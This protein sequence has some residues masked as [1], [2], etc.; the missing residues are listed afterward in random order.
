MNEQFYKEMNLDSTVLYS[1]DKIK[2]LI[3]KNLIVYIN[4]K[5][6]KT[7]KNS[8][9]SFEEWS[10]TWFSYN[11]SNV[12]NMSLLDKNVREILKGYFWLNPLINAKKSNRIKIKLRRSSLNRILFSKP[13]IRQ[14][15]NKTIITLYIYNKDKKFSYFKLNKLRIKKLNKRNEIQ[16]SIISKKI[17]KKNIAISSVNNKRKITQKNIPENLLI[18][19]KENA[20]KKIKQNTLSKRKI[21]L[22]KRKS[23]YFLHNIIK[24]KYFFMKSLEL[25]NKYFNIKDYINNHHS[26]Y[27]NKLYKREILYLY[28]IKIISINNIRF[29]NWFLLGLKNIISN[30]Y[31]KNIELNLVNL[32]YL[33]YNSNILS[34]AVSIKL[35]NRNLKPLKVLKKAMSMIRIPYIEPFL[36]KN[37]EIQQERVKDENKSNDLIS[38]LKEIKNKTINGVRIETTGRLS[39]RLTASRSVFKYKY[40]G[41]LKNIESSYGRMSSKILRGHVKQNIQFV[42]IDS[43]G[44]NGAFGLKGWTST[45]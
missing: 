4:N 21:K 45:F 36:Y 37:V 5:K 3:N 17:N 22:I 14:T 27:L 9:P 30:I 6:K 15:N 39:K 18:N 29:K 35:K 1:E 13:E 8:L 24:H 10:N 7:E 28:Y 25:N 20:Y 26:N 12:V 16:N 32:K 2:T 41:T 23:R 43:K 34:E 31:K 44:R 38:I 11:K 33:H 40:K 19:R 42:K